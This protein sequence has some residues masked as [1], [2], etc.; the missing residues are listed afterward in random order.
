MKADTSAEKFISVATLFCK[1]EDDYFPIMAKYD[2]KIKK[3][4]LNKFFFLIELLQNIKQ[5]TQIGKLTRWTS[6]TSN[7][8]HSSHFLLL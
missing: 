1:K 6:L 5:F 3:I 2:T 8:A 7:Y 4:A